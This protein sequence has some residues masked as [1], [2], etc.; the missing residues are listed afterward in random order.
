MDKIEQQKN[1]FENISEKYYKSRQTRNHL[2]LKDLMWNY[3]FKNKDYLK[4]DGLHVLEPMCGYG[5]GKDILEKNLKIKIVYSGFDY[6]S[7]LIK[8]IKEF[9]PT[10]DVIEMDITKFI[11]SKK[12]DLVIIIGGLHHVP[13]HLDMVLDKLY[14]SLNKNGY[15]IYLEPTHNNILFKKIRERIYKKNEFFDNDTERAFE[16]VKINQAFLDHNFKVIDQIYP[17]LLSYILY[18]NPDAFPILN[19]G[20]GKL[21]K[22]FFNFDKLFFRNF[23]GRKLSFAT[24]TLL[25]KNEKK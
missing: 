9:D 18:Y 10:T 5:E 24:L 16:L 7:N 3:F 19:K 12:Y 8:K 4:N 6:S 2:L 17:G 22:A 25:Q 1:H 23:I 20:S 13:F 21:V 11:P 14:E 15:F